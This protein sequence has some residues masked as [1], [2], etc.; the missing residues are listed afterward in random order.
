MT[1]D[2]GER[3]EKAVENTVGFRRPCAKVGVS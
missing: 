3:R 2:G 1:D